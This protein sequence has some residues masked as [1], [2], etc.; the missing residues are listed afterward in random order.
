MKISKFFSIKYGTSR[1][2]IISN[3]VQIC[4]AHTAPEAFVTIM[5]TVHGTHVFSCNK[6]SS[7]NTA[8]TQNVRKFAQTL[9][10]KVF[11]IYPFC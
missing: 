11:N 9:V 3:G 8:N 4:S 5:P 7:S 2:K 1:M 6:I 10:F